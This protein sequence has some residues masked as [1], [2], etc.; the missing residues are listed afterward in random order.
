MSAPTTPAKVDEIKDIA[1]NSQRK[2]KIARI[3]KE[4]IFMHDDLQRIR[5]SLI[6]EEAHLS[7]KRRSDREVPEYYDLVKSWAAQLYDNLPAIKNELKVP[8]GLLIFNS[9]ILSPNRLQYD[10]FPES[11]IS[12]PGVV[13]VI[14]TQR[15]KDM[16]DKLM[17]FTTKDEGCLRGPKGVGK[18]FLLLL[19]MLKL[20]ANAENRVI[21]INNLAAV[22][23]AGNLYMAN[24]LVYAFYQDMKDFP[25]PN[26]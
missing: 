4:K 9:T 8:S 11:N 15:M 18:S 5:L 20:R 6:E 14:Y 1:P 21:Y 26:K 2:R 23:N 16:I 12:E 7:G 13:E 3:D 17:K 24:E 19:L 25:S 22:R 10:R